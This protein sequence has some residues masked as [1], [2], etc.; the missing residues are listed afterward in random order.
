VIEEVEDDPSATTQRI[1][2]FREYQQ[3]GTALGHMPNSNGDDAR[4]RQQRQRF[5]LE[6]LHKERDDLAAL[7]KRMMLAQSEVL[8]A[9]IPRQP[10]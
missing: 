4:L 1:E 2:M 7:A 10:L 3:A 8:R 9:I 6:D 5:F